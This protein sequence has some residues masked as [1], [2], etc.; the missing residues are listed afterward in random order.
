M[1][2][3]TTH[4]LPP[5][6]NVLCTLSICYLTAGI[7]HD[8]KQLANMK[9]V[10]E[11]NFKRKA[12]IESTLEFEGSCP[13]LHTTSPLRD[14]LLTHSCSFVLSFA[15]LLCR[16]RV[17]EEPGVKAHLHAQAQGEGSRGCEEI[18][19]SVHVGEK[20]SAGLSGP[21]HAEREWGVHV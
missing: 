5:V 9:S 14:T 4:V 12:E 1:A 6:L 3:S 2:A 13:T 16:C 15:R 8:A 21:P 7:V 10:K 17:R 19:A 18:A 20:G 11:R